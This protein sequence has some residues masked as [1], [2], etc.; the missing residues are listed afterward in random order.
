MDKEVAMLEFRLRHQ[1][2]VRSGFGTID[3]Q[4]QFLHAAFKQ[5]DSSGNGFLSFDEYKIAMKNLNFILKDEKVLEVLFNKWDTNMNGMLDYTEFSKGLYAPGTRVTSPTA[6]RT[7]IPCNSG[8]F[9]SAPKYGASNSTT[10]RLSSIN[11]EPAPLMPSKFSEVERKMLFDVSDDDKLELMWKLVDF[12]GN[13][14][15]TLAEID[16]FVVERY[17]SLDHKPALM[18]AYKRTISRVGGGSFTFSYL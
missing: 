9:T 7:D 5:Y 11:V 17:P 6:A 14:G 18:R 10:V 1:F 3:K 2:E 13:G 4:R 16:K 12:N 8:N 15:S